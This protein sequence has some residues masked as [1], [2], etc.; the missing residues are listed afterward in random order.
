MMNWKKTAVFPAALLGCLV[1]SGCFGVFGGREVS[2][3]RVY[4]IGF[5]PQK[6]SQEFAACNLDVANF[7]SDSSARFKMLFRHGNELK[8]SENC[9]WAQ[10]PQE[11]LTRYFRIVF[12]SQS[13]APYRLE[14]LLLAFESDPA[15]KVCR[16]F[17]RYSVCRTSDDRTVYSGISRI[18]IPL[19]GNAEPGSGFADAMHKAVEQLVTEIGEKVRKLPQEETHS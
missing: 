14:G 2:V 3:T 10:T 8:P 1:L 7:A 19:P 5:P 6:L 15:E 9:R 17:F 18:V 4:D 13:N 11:M 12:G 16:L